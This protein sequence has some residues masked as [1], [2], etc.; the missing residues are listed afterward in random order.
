M[1]ICVG[2]VLTSIQAYGHIEDIE[3][4]SGFVVLCDGAFAHRHHAFQTLLA[5]LSSLRSQI[6][7]LFMNRVIYP[8]LCISHQMR[9]AAAEHTQS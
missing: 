2:E 1:I 4:V 5:V 3:M 8:S 9:D 7:L 6:K